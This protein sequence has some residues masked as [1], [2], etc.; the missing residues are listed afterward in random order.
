MCVQWSECTD[1]PA[2]ESEI[3]RIEEVIVDPPE[4]AMIFFGHDRPAGDSNCKVQ[5]ISR[6]RHVAF[7]LATSG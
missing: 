1:F 3:S 7:N 2:P 4:R 6:Q 5:N